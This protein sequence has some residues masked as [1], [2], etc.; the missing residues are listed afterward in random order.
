MAKTN[1]RIWQPKR[2]YKGT[3]AVTLVPSKI[4]DAKVVIGQIPPNATQVRIEGVFKSAIIKN[5][6]QSKG[7]I[8]IA[9]TSE[10]HEI[11]AMLPEKLVISQKYIYNDTIHTLV[12][13]YA[14][15][16]ANYHNF[17]DQNGV[18]IYIHEKNVPNWIFNYK[19]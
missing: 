4:K 11:E 7:Q 1:I 16:N 18:D 6:T 10:L 5:W 19:K 13:I 12:V 17:I 15:V 3:Y 14:G 8:V 2:N 9:Y